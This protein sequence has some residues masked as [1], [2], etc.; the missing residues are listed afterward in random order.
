MISFRIMQKPES[1]NTLAR[2]TFWAY[3]RVF[4]MWYTL[5]GAALS[6]VDAQ[7]VAGPVRLEVTARWKT[8]RRHDID[9][10]L[11]KPVLDAMVKREILR[12][13][14]VNDIVE[15]KLRGLIDQSEDSLQI[16][17]IPVV[18]RSQ[19]GTDGPPDS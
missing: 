19:G 12:D 1:W 8:K 4:E 16:D 18:L 2:K 7:P 10:I 5:T 9:N 11:L 14:G 17:I 6:E 3:K 15:I 13:D